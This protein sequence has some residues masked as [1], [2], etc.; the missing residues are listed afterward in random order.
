[1]FRI[2]GIKPLIFSVITVGVL[3]LVVAL[4]TA[5]LA[6]VFNSNEDNIVYIILYS[7]FIIATL[8]LLTPIV[9]ISKVKKIIIGICVN[10]SIIGFP[11][12][13]LLITGIISMHQDDACRAEID[14]YQTYN[15]CNTLIESIGLY[16]SFVYFILTILFLIF[17]TKVI[18]NWKALPEG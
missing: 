4:L 3:A 12:Y 14:Y 7:V 1:M 13:L 11:L 16:W 18:K 8:I 2:T 15:Q 9:F 5:L 10:I 6:F 17:Y